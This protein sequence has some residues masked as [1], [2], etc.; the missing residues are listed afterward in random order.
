MAGNAPQ[1]G[2]W[3]ATATPTAHPPRIVKQRGTQGMNQTQRYSQP[4]PNE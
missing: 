3:N 4:D 1:P 2:L